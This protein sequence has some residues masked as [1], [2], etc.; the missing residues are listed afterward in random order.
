MESIKRNLSGGHKPIR[1]LSIIMFSSITV[2]RKRNLDFVQ[3]SSSYG[4][5]LLK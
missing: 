1:M 4:D 5:K 3:S 2:T